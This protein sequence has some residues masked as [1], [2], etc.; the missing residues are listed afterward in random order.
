MQASSEMTR[1][2]RLHLS[3]DPGSGLLDG[4]WWPWS[5][6]L[7][8]EVADLV[9][10]FPP[11]VGRVARVLF[12]RPDWSSHPRHVRVGRGMVK[13]GSFPS[14]DTHQVLLTLKRDQRLTVLVVPAG[15]A[16]EA[17]ELLVADALDPA[18]RRTAAELVGATRGD[19]GA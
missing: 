15:T 17:A 8:T 16:P 12:S 5:D 11:E 10:H 2:L 13:T 19:D 9:D 3:P 6:D 7:E 1:P 4:V 14:D 18:N